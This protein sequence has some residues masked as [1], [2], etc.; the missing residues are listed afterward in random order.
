MTRDTKPWVEPNSSDIFN[1]PFYHEP[2]DDNDLA[3]P[4]NKISAREVASLIV[5]GS[6]TIGAGV[7]MLLRHGVREAHKRVERDQNN[8]KWLFEVAAEKAAE[9]KAK[10][11]S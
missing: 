6:A 7:A 10:R 5:I 2:F 1:D 3:E 11:K 8:V 9:R 4:S